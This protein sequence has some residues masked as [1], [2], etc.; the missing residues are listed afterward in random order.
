MPLGLP[1]PASGPHSPPSQTGSGDSQQRAPCGTNPEQAAGASRAGRSR[2]SGRS[3][4]GSA[5]PAHSS[6]QTP[7]TGRARPRGLPGFQTEP[8]WSRPAHFAPFVSGVE[9]KKDRKSLPTRPSCARALCGR[10]ARVLCRPRSSPCRGLTRG[11][12]RDWGPSVTAGTAAPPNAG[13]QRGERRI[14][15]HSP[16]VRRPAGSGHARR[17]G[18]P[19]CCRD[20]GASLKVALGRGRGRRQLP[21]TASSS[22]GQ[23]A[24]SC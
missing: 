18:L 1:L 21:P 17:A 3:A 4:E 10:V 12:R 6:S 15:G 23:D 9:G 19:R 5:R 14:R 8:L 11:P 2:G 13:R 7:A 16:S 20:S 22:A 24:V